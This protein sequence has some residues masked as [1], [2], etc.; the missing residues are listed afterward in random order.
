MTATLLLIGHTAPY[1][2]QAFCTKFTCYV[3]QLDWTSWIHGVFN[4]L[5]FFVMLV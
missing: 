3:S 2:Q 4:S 1:P 5:L